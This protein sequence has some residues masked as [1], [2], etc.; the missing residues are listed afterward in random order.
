[1]GMDEKAMIEKCKNGDLASFEALFALY[2]EKIYQIAYRYFGNSED[3]QDL[4]QEA[5]IKIY[6]NINQY[7]GEAQFSTYVFRI[8]TNLCYDELR[9]RK[10][11]KEEPIDKELELE[12]GKVI[13]QIAGTLDSP[14]EKLERR[15]KQKVLQHYIAKL[16]LEQRTVV[17]LRDIEGFSY[18]EIATFLDCSLGTVKSRISR[19]RQTLKSMLSGEEL[20]VEEQRQ[21]RGKGGQA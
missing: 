20:F 19:G 4:T 18:E 7:R 15:E 8:A 10:R 21:I 5:F 14:E 6:R 3:A 16:P 17:I 12:D 9:K 1:M 13:V 11:K 2:G